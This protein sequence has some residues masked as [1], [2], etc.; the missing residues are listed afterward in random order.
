MAITYK[1]ELNSKPKADGTH[2]ILLRITEN[3]KLKR[4]ST[5]IFITPKH[6]NKNA[7]PGK[8]IRKTNPEFA[9][10]ND[11]LEELIKDAR[12]AKGVLQSKRQ[13]VSKENIISLM[14]EVNT[15]SFISYWEAELPIIKEA[16]SI[17]FYRNCKS[18]LNNL[19]VY[20]NGKD[21]LFTGIDAKFLKGYEAHMKKKGNS[22][23]TIV[24]NLKMIRII[25]YY[26]IKDKDKKLNV[27]NPFA[28]YSLKEKSANKKKLTEAEVVSLTKLKLDEYTDL[29]H[30]R[31]Y[32]IFAMYCA[33]MR[34]R[35]LMQL[36]WSNIHGNHLI[37]DM[38]KN[39]KNQTIQLLPQAEA[40]LNLY[41]PTKAKQ[42]NYVFP[43]LRNDVQYDRELL[44][45]TIQSHTAIINHKL[46][47]VADLAEIETNL[48]THISRHTFAQIASQKGINTYDLQKLLKHSSL[49]QTETYLEQLNNESANK[50]LQKFV[51]DN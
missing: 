23:N 50:A 8:W 28:E 31:N 20:L 14:K 1:L 2:G 45:K 9:V 39:K 16:K 35:D 43:I 24:T 30:V 38:N 13:T 11:E 18:K 47:Q 12:K 4:I 5:G 27:Q 32:F 29:W 34:I 22:H 42:S 25:F 15:D 19:K 48:S 46:K 33:G 36:K 37:Y 21:L 26:A 10:L 40:I 7:E 17:D 6:F 51:I 44:S 3:R 49:K 41:K